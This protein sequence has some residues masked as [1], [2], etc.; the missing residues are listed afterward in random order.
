MQLPRDKVGSGVL[1]AVRV[2]GDS[3]I[4]A[5]IHEGDYVVVRQQDSADNGDIVAAL[6]GE[7]EAIVKTF[8]YADGHVWLIS[9]NPSY[10][11]ILGDNCRVM[12]R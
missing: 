9:Q 4:N 10:Q 12:G 1:F 11:P 8:H 2:V 6:I 3:M 7:E 5:S